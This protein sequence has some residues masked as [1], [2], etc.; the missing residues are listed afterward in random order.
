MDRTG[1]LKELQAALRYLH[2]QKIDENTAY[3]QLKDNPRFEGWIR[4]PKVK[5]IYK[6]LSSERTKSAKTRSSKPLIKE[7][8]ANFI[9]QIKKC[10]VPFFK[11]TLQCNH[12]LHPCLNS[13]RG[14]SADARFIL[15]RVQL[16][17]SDDFYKL[18]V[19]DV[20]SN[21]ERYVKL[22]KTLDA[23]LV[24]FIF[25]NAD[26]GFSF[27]FNGEFFDVSLIEL[28]WSN[29]NMQV[30]QM[31]RL[32]F[33]VPSSF[34]CNPADST[35][36]IY[37]TRMDPAGAFANVYKFENNEVVLEHSN[38]LESWPS[39]CSS[40]FFEGKLYGFEHRNELGELPSPSIHVN[41]FEPN[42]STSVFALEWPSNNFQI[43]FLSDAMI[44]TWIRDRFYAVVKFDEDDTFGIAWVSCETTDWALLD[45]RTV[46]PIFSLRF[47]VEPSIL[48]VQTADGETELDDS[49]IHQIKST[50]YRIPLK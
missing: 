43:F 2:S 4:L 11:T 16:Q 6:Q 38:F 1:R 45:F 42:A 47:I 5:T 36:F 12:E 27:K 49:S 15:H 35:R 30:V 19:H 8:S 13:S 40:S 44:Y 3:D 34:M 48:F 28:D 17:P 37:T 29:E 18:L 26:F 20:F 25:L 31:I 50:V 32:P 41:N 46:E 33:E 22:Q 24:G 21:K 10:A 39:F 9:S 7:P 23:E 14:F